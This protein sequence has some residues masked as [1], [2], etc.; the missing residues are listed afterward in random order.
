MN[1]KNAT[2][3]NKQKGITLIALVITIIVI[4]ILSGITLNALSGENGILKRATQAKE[5][6]NR[7]QVQEQL[8][9]E[10]YDVFA[11]EG[12]F[13]ADKFKEKVQQDLSDINP[14]IH[15]KENGDIVVETDKD[16]F[17]IDGQTGEIKES[18]PKGG[19][20]PEVE[21]GVTQVGGDPLEKDQ[22]YEEVE[23]HVTVPNKDEFDE[24]VE[25]TVKDSEGQDVEVQWEDDGQGGKK[26]VVPGTGDY[27]IE[28]KGTK[29][30][31]EKT[32]KKT[33]HVGDKKPEPEEPKDT[34]KPIITKTEV[35]T[36]WTNADKQ[37]TVQAEDRKGEGA[38]EYASGI[39]AY[40]LTSNRDEPQEKDWKIEESGTWT[41]DPAGLG[42]HYAWVKDKAGNI[43]EPSEITIEKIESGTPTVNVEIDEEATK[44]KQSHTPK[45]SISDDTSGLKTGT[46][47]VKYTWTQDDNEP[48]WSEISGI[49]Y[50]TTIQVEE[51]GKQ[52]VTVSLPEKK[53]LTGTYYLHVQAL[54]LQDVAGN[55][56]DS[57]TYGVYKFDNKGPKIT[58][59]PQTEVEYKQSQKTK[60]TVTDEEET[61]IN[62][63]SLKYVWKQEENIESAQEPGT[64]EFQKTYTNQ[65]EATHSEGTGENW[66]I[67]AVAEDN[68]GNKTIDKTGPFYLDNE[69]PDDSAP[70]LQSTT[71]SIT[72]TFNQKD[73]NKAGIDTESK[74]YS[75]KKNT[76]GEDEWSEWKTFEGTT[77]TI[78]KLTLG[79]KYDVRTKSSDIL[80][81]G[82]K[83]SKTASIDT[84]DIEK[85]QIN[86][87]NTNNTNKDVKIKITYPTT[88]EGLTNE[89]KIEPT[90][91][92]SEQEEK[93]WE[94]Y[95]FGEDGFEVKAN[96]TIYARTR[97]NDYQGSDDTRV[98]T[99]TL[100]NIDKK[101]PIISS[102][103]A[104]TELTNTDKA[105]T[106]QAEDQGIAGLEAYAIT[107]SDQNTKEQI[108]ADAWK[109]EKA[110]EW[111]SDTKYD[112]GTYYAWAK[113]TL[114]NI[115]D[116]YTVQITNVDKKP[117]EASHTKTTAADKKSVTI[118]ITGTDE[119]GIQSIETTD[120]V[121]ITKQSGEETTATTR[122]TKFTVTEN[123]TYHF[124][125]TDKVGNSKTYN[126]EVT[127]IEIKTGAFTTEFGT[128]DVVWLNTSNEI[129]SSP[130]AP[131]VGSESPLTPVKWNG[132][133]EED[134]STED[135][136]WYNYIAG[137]GTEDN[138]SSHWANAKKSDGSYFV[139][140]PRFAYRITY[141]QDETRQVVTGYEDARGIVDAQGNQKYALDTGIKTVTSGNK[142][143][144]VHPAFMNNT[145]N[146]FDN[147]G[148]DSDLSGFWVAKYEM[149]RT[150][151][152][153]NSPGTWGG[154]KFQ[155]K[156]LVASA[157]EIKIGDMYTYGKAYLSGKSSHMMKNSEWGA[158]A[159]LTHSQYGRNGHEIYINNYSD[160]VT[161]L[162]GNSAS[163]YLSYSITNKYNTE[164]GQM[165]SST[166]NIYG[167]YDLSGGAYEYVAAFDREGDNNLGTYG[168]SIVSGGK[169][170]T[171][172][173]TAYT[174]G[175][176]KDDGDTIYTVSK[177]GDMTKEVRKYSSSNSSWFSD[178]AY[179]LYDVEPFCLR[180]GEYTG[181]G[182]AGLF[183]SANA[184]GNTATGHG[185]RVV[186]AP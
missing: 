90:E 78:P 40:A 75:Y 5:L 64:E 63:N 20:W 44:T 135:Q 62:D 104:P 14:Q 43:S 153:L 182:I 124:T 143:Y 48:T 52:K 67:W 96:C 49:E 74:Q 73:N 16:E 132:I 60:I 6:T 149:S 38:N 140:I 184:Q 121:D 106:V 173:A 109:E 112:A 117:P 7:A 89:Y 126:V 77:A 25:I 145:E 37:V 107:T 45:I 155:S 11:E 53:D 3:I 156:P 154:T 136:N 85:P 17:I 122:K 56:G 165:A 111:T 172:W 158:V 157:S 47:T 93:D 166:G 59:E 167:I 171:K 123:A 116:P 176:L 87:T 164:V 32:E 50:Q 36:D 110:G 42:M 141:Y 114:G 98:A 91:V 61:A 82:P 142:S 113:D 147:G 2:Y 79:I 39:Q 66:Y 118:E 34:T 125:I 174:N 8:Q 138:N 150:D 1:T 108:P 175:T 54:S 88:G 185:F 127:E 31:I 133:E 13:N 119:N 94:I 69:E 22:T 159:C 30:G 103:T 134:T 68:L 101:A 102:A 144:I 115:S 120:K 139:W 24:E 151:A 57:T 179:V 12:D 18:G 178:L 9:L 105:I 186:L 21:V 84:K 80:G 92:D 170:S 129:I 181:E 4:L 35:S 163:A 148:W 71:N 169:R 76:Q 70:V 162:A 41:S 10:V 29:D 152:T 86:V 28:V 33:V 58:F 146:N 160:H 131:V 95:D 51:A 99:A 81:N 177:T 83:I 23:L 26:A 180:G 15:D 130:N 161:G 72:V 128:I 100:T 168:N 27:T 46:Y 19:L 65:G 97:D 55:T 137:T 183:C